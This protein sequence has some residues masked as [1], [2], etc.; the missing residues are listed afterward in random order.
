[1][2]QLYSVTVSALVVVFNFVVSARR[3]HTVEARDLRLSRGKRLLILKRLTGGHRG[4]RQSR[5]VRAW[6][7]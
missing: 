3:S 4:G 6:E 7:D 5:E 2:G 1:M